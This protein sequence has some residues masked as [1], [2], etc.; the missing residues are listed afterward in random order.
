MPK[1]R[2]IFCDGTVSEVIVSAELLA[3]LKE[4]DRQERAG[5]RRHSGHNVSYERHR[6][7]EEQHDKTRD[8]DFEGVSK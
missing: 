8:K 7:H 6:R 3:E 4:C 1:Y 5:N 2:Y